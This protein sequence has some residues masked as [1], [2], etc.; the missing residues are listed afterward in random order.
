MCN[1]RDDV[2]WRM[3]STQRGA[4]TTMTLIVIDGWS[5]SRLSGFLGLK[6][7]CREHMFEA[8]VEGVRIDPGEVTVP[9][10]RNA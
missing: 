4:G 3:Q 2:L 10:F 5:E 6:A 7:P 9:R 1:K 8:S